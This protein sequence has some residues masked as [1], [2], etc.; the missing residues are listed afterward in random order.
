M[1]R[2]TLFLMLLLAAIGRVAHAQVFGTVRVVARDAQN[3]AVTNADVV[4]KAKSSDWTR[5]GKTNAQGEALFVA[6]PFGEYIV[7]VK[8]EGFRA[9]GPADPSDLK[10][11][12]AC[13]G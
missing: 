9:G 12:D 11:S 3:L 8:A 2:K 4:I 1:S 7:T 6:V 10:R 13:A 5:A